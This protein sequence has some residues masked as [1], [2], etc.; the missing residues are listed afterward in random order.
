[1][2][3]IIHGAYDATAYVGVARASSIGVQLRVGMIALGLIV[4]V[5]V[6]WRKKPYKPAD[7]ASDV[8]QGGLKN[9][10]NQLAR[11]YDVF[12]ANHRA[13]TRRITETVSIITKIIKFVVCL[14]VILL[15]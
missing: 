9:I 2:P 8:R 4:A 3:A 14:C 1:M 15:K 11:S 13:I 10:V 12:S 5:F 6:F 7:K